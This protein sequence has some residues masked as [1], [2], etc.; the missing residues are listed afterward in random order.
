MSIRFLTSAQIELD[1]AIAYY[2][3]EKPNLGNDFLSEVLAAFDRIVKYP[4]AW[5]KIS[6]RTH[7]CV[8]RRFPY[9]IIYQ[10]RKT[11]ILIVAVAHSHRKPEY[12]QDRL[13]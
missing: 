13:E 10:I 4:N 12:W 11:E 1:E 3:Y 2:N 8:I 5:P 6:A 7:R 9:Y